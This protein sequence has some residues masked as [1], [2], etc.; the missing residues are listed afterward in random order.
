MKPLSASATF[1]F[2]ASSHCRAPRVASWRIV[3]PFHRAHHVM[4]LVIF[5]GEQV[6][7]G[8]AVCDPS[9]SSSCWR[10]LNLGCAPSGRR[11][12][13]KTRTAP[14]CQP[15][16]HVSWTAAHRTTVIGR[17]PGK[18]GAYLRVVLLSGQLIILGD[19]LFLIEHLASHVVLFLTRHAARQLENQV[20]G[21]ACRECGRRSKGGL[22]QRQQQRGAVPHRLAGFGDF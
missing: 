22:R 15:V 3:R 17:R 16:H 2:S 8:L 9:S 7:R 1:A 20:S 18:G 5:G 12:C 21:G 19:E 13:T 10:S 14:P 11:P 4:V 6:Q